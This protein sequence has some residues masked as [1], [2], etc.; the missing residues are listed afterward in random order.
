MSPE[1][2]RAAWQGRIAAANALG[3]AL[4]TAASGP[5]Y[6]AFGELA[7]LAMAPVALAGLVMVVMAWRL[8]PQS[9][10]VGGNTRLPS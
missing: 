4:A 7:Y 8:Y 10:G 2:A 6:R 3:M 1:G 5:L 9:V